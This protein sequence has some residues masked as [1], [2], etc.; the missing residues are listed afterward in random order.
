MFESIRRVSERP[1]KTA[2]CNGLIKHR[3]QKKRSQIMNYEALEIRQLMATLVGNNA[4]TYQDVDGD[5]VAVN[6]SSGFLTSA[7]VNSVLQFDTST[8]NGSNAVRQQLRSIN[9]GGLTAAA[10]SAIAT[11]V[12]RNLGTGG[13]GRVN[14]GQ[15]I[16]TGID[17]G[18]VT[19]NGDLG[20]IRAGDTN[21]GSRAAGVISVNSLGAL[22]TST[23]AVDNDTEAAG[24]IRALNV[25]GGIFNAYIRTEHGGDIESLTISG[26]L[27]GGSLSNSGSI[28]SSGA[29]GDITMGGSLFGGAGWNSGSI[30]A[31]GSIG[32]ITIGG[33]LFGSNGL[34]TGS[35]DSQQEI[36][37]VTI[38][39]SIFG[40]YGT[41]SGRV[42]SE[43]EMGTV[44]VAGSIVGNSGDNS[45]QV[46]SR[47]ANS[48]TVDGS[49]I[50]GGGDGS[51]QVRLSGPRASIVV[52]GDLV[53]GNGGN[54]GT[55]GAR[56]SART[57][58]VQGS[59]RGG[60][61]NA[62]GGIAID[63]LQ[64]L[65][66]GG[67]LV[68][69]NGSY[70][71]R[72]F[73]D[74][75]TNL[76]INGDVSGGSATGTSSLFFSGSISVGTARN[77]TVGSLISG[78]DGTSGEYL[79]NG[80]IVA[81]N[82]IE[83][84]RI[85]RN[86]IGNSSNPALIQAR[87]QASPSGRSDFAFGSITIGGDVT[88]S[89]FIAGINSSRFLSNADAQIGAVVVNGNWTASDLLAGA[90]HHGGGF[91]AKFSGTGVT[92]STRI[93]S[94]IASITIGG[95]VRGTTSAGDH[96]A[97]AAE[98]IG[99]LKIG[100]TSYALTSGPSNDNR[101]LDALFADVRLIEV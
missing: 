84:L 8:V 88:R 14:I 79:N 31:I 48:I 26:S 35:I 54:S 22:G 9:L 99:R 75:I 58:T 21:Y 19:V 83:N 68:G 32:D 18:N 65:T 87:G 4:V 47:V 13:D 77:L 100:A 24:S 33:S 40:G 43:L 64:S 61:G 51:G 98:N 60:S 30:A 96:F 89:K 74:R 90:Q 42:S 41:E 28:Y 36:D 56:G 25:S 16:A 95:T 93:R 86:V 94:S 20:R 34:G 82:N 62:S 39:G 29:I 55:I 70:S 91:Y 27:F 23:G 11:A 57:F 63:A 15:I 80:A 92:D 101:L 72:V 37:S 53:G 1:A 52:R 59:V 85:L 71:G 67:G 73:V 44:Y 50:G 46:Y 6:F 7:N 66:I 78:F 81:S 17:L 38:R 45:G 2:M 3:T 5:S 49:V 97:F 12:V 69:G 76:T 10:R